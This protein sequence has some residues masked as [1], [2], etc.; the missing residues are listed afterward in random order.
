MGLTSWKNSP[1]GKIIKTDVSIAKNYLNKTE[2]ESLGRIVN[3]FLDLA[4]NRAERNI[5]M[6]MQDWA[7]RIDAFLEFDERKI[8]KD[9]G[10]ISAQIAKEKAETEFEKYRIIQ[11]RLFRSDFDKEIM[12]QLPKN[13]KN[14]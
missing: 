4:E 13:N 1:E 5:P 7:K 10:K 6:T 8:L 9:E 14:D 12:K 3:A 2:L 11:D